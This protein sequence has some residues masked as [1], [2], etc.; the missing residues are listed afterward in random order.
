MAQPFGKQS[1]LQR[2]FTSSLMEEVKELEE[3]IEAVE[4]KIDDPVICDKIKQFVT[5]PKEIQSLFKADAKDENINVLA[6]VLRS[7]D[8]PALSRPQMNRVMRSHRAHIAYLRQRS[9]MAD[10]DDDEGPDDEDAWLFEDLAVLT[11]LYSR[12]RDRQQII[13]LIF[14]V[15]HPRQ[16]SQGV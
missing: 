13:E 9:N 12:L 5:A 2:M 1:L 16:H 3:D 11:K 8:A 14:E 15:Y 7:G 4:D 6:V 10:S